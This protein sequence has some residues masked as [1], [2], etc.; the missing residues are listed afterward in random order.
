MHCEKCGKELGSDAR[1]CPAC[2]NHVEVSYVSKT[3]IKSN[4][5]TARLPIIFG[6]IT[7]FFVSCLFTGLFRASFDLQLIVLFIALGMAIPSLITGIVGYAKKYNAHV[8]GF[9]F[10]IVSMALVIV[11]FIG[12]MMRYW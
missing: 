1:F 10:G 4:K 12:I 2:G 11:Y 7:M 8:V 9:T 3:T 5:P 6:S